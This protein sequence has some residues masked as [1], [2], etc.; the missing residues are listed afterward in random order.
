MYI[1]L[2]GR[3]I[4][5]HYQLMTIAKQFLVYREI[6]KTLLVS[7]TI[8]N[9]KTIIDKNIPKLF[10]FENFTE[11]DLDN[12]CRCNY[13]FIIFT[14]RKLPINLS[15]TYVPLIIS[16]P[17]DTDVVQGQQIELSINLTNYKLIDCNDCRIIY[18]NID[19]INFFRDRL[20]NDIKE[21][22][23]RIGV[24]HTNQ[25]SVVYTDNTEELFTLTGQKSTFAYQN[26]VIGLFYKKGM[27]RP[28]IH[29][30]TH[31]VLYS[32]GTPP[33]L[34]L[35]GIATMM[36]EFLYSTSKTKS[37]DILSQRYITENPNFSLS[38]LLN[39]HYQSH[40]FHTHFYSIS[41][42]FVSFL[43]T[44][45]KIEG[46]L[47]CYFSLSRNKSLQENL[48]IFSEIVGSSFFEVEAAWKK[49]ILRK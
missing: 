26:K 15:S 46:V 22:E 35:E 14:K 3:E 37:F 39:T 36:S 47:Q 13:E 2:D 10:Y 8:S 40:N 19:N 24:K 1:K 44:L 16:L 27:F 48:Q 9:S 21:I 49:T 38:S 25:F 34:F 20:L 45:V 7:G 5:K 33:F 41:A 11:K 42:S 23:N 32:Y 29:E 31:L 12:L 6:G 4:Y 28:D 18:K 30:I 43:I 17:N